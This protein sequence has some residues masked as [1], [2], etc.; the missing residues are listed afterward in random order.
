M[1]LKNLSKIIHRYFRIP[2]SSALDNA[3]GWSPYSSEDNYLRI[4][5]D[6]DIESK[7]ENSFLT[8]R[9]KFWEDLEAA[10]SSSKNASNVLRV[11][12]IFLSVFLLISWQLIQT[13]KLLFS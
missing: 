7:M 3:T 8:E 6:T 2:M 1:R 5:N 4:G 13:A 9:M 10:T 12:S 11:P